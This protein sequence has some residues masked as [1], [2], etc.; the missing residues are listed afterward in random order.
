M[1]ELAVGLGCGV[2]KL[3]TSFMGL[4]LGASFKSLRMWDVVEE[5][6]RKKLFMWKL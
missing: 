5:I 3:S 4:P 6:F 1:E 2:G